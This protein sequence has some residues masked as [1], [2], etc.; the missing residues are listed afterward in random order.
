MLH[1]L[2]AWR[3]KRPP[4]EKFQTTQ[5]RAKKTLLRKTILKL[6]RLKTK[7]LALKRLYKELW[8][9]ML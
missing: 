2:P 8:E 4:N 6:H 9:M 3:R 7:G 5:E 1:Q